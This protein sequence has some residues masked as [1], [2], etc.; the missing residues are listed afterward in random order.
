MMIMT[1]TFLSAINRQA[2]NR[3]DDGAGLALRPLD[4]AADAALLRQWFSMDYARFWSMQEHTEAQVR[5]FYEALADSGH[6]AAWLGSHQDRPAFLLECYDPAHDQVGEHYP[7]CHGD[8]GMHIFIGPPEVRIPH[9][10]RRVFAFVM[11]FLFDRLHAR[12]VVVEPDSNNIKI[13]ALNLAMGFSY[14]GQARFR[15]KTASIAFCTRRQ[16][17]QAQLQES[18]L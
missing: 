15:E 18:S 8:L 7:V 3:Y 12:R 13:H 5:E 14:A 11:R 17:E 4:P 9:F 1:A 6:A 2:R 10:S 16:F